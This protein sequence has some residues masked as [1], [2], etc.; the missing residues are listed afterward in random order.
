MLSHGSSFNLPFFHLIALKTLAQVYLMVILFIIY[1]CSAHD[2]H[3][4]T[5]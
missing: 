5:M 3:S 2:M 4:V 1:M